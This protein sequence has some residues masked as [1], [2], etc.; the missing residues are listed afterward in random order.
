MRQNERR[1][2]FNRVGKPNSGLAQGSAKPLLRLAANFYSL[3]T[4]IAC[5]NGGIGDWLGCY[6]VGNRVGILPNTGSGNW[7]V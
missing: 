2:K 6:R 3:K 5:W 4:E 7:S 1:I